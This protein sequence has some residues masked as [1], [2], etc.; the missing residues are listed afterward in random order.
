MADPPW[1]AVEILLAVRL[2]VYCG[3]R[4]STKKRRKGKW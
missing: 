1:E 4:T 2:L 3:G